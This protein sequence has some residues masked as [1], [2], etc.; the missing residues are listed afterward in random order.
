MFRNHPIGLL[1]FA[2][3]LHPAAL[4]AREIYL[5]PPPTGDDSSGNG[6]LGS[7]YATLRHALGQAVSGDVLTLR[8]GEY[9]G[10]VTVATP[11]LTLRSHPDEWAVVQAPIDD[12]GVGNALW[13]NTTGTRL[14]RLELIGGYYYALKFE[15]GDALVSRCRIHGSGRDAVKIVPGADDI[16]LEFCEIYD[17]GLRDDSNAE[18]IDN[19]N[20]DRMIVRD[21]YVHDTGTNC[22]Y[23]TGGAIGVVFERCLFA[24][25]G[26]AG[27]M[28]GQ[29]SGT[30]FLD[31]VQNP[32][33]KESIDGVVRNCIVVDTPGA[34]IAMQAALRPR[35]HNNT[36]VD[37]AESG[38]GGLYVASTTH[39]GETR[40]SEDI[41]LINNIV[42]L[43]ATSPRPI[44]FITASGLTGG[45][46]MDH[47]RYH[48]VGDSPVFWDERV[49][50][51]GWSLADW[52]SNTGQGAHSSA[53]DPDL[54]ADQHLASDGGPCVGSGQTLAS[55]LDDYDGNLRSVPYDLGADQRGDSALAVPPAAGTLGTGRDGETPGVDAGAGSDGGADL[56]SG[57][58]SDASGSSDVASTT[59]AGAVADTGT[60]TGTGSDAG[61]VADDGG[62]SGT[63]DAADDSQ[64]VEEGCSCRSA[65]TTNPALILGVA[66][67]AWRHR[68]RG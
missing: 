67:L 60:D 56:D 8:S 43:S 54:D 27:V 65:S 2:T 48:K 28:L 42:V 55:V 15:Q 58:L 40:A 6:D 50:A 30:E 29:S 44:V 49:G 39:L 10:G 61:G 59:D 32:T 24:R 38:N 11:D 41:E 22:A 37:V 3:L 23:A 19:V 7:P 45:L 62:P 26:H 25:C 18:G 52:Q 9:V 64:V 66:L 34:G 20:G 31:P 14:Q 57:E 21:S 63:A 33:Y 17:S 36:L 46:S 5:A 53:G 16:T 51:Y 47:N 35:V 68:R 12:S 1:L 13:V 4:Q